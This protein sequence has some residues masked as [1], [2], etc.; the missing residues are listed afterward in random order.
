MTR[1]RAWSA[2]YAAQ[3]E[4]LVVGTLTWTADQHRKSAADRPDSKANRRATMPGGKGINQRPPLP[5]WVRVYLIG[6]VGK[7]Y[8]GS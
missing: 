5:G 1:A 8:D 7:D 6:K 4:D 2:D 3:Q